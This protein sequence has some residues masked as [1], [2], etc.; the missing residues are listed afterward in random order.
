MMTTDIVYRTMVNARLMGVPGERIAAQVAAG[1]GVLG[2]QQW[3][4]EFDAQWEW[5]VA[6]RIVPTEGPDAVSFY[7]SMRRIV[8]RQLALRE[9]PPAAP[10]GM[11]FPIGGLPSSTEDALS[12]VFAVPFEAYSVEAQASMMGIRLDGDAKKSVM[13][14]S[15]N[16]RLMIAMDVRFGDPLRGNDAAQAAPLEVALALLRLRTFRRSL[17]VYHGASLR[18]VQEERGLA[19]CRRAESGAAAAAV[20][21]D[22]IIEIPMVRP[23]AVSVTRPSA[24][25]PARAAAPPS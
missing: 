1:E 12:F 24:P 18:V 13:P 3:E 23:A 7:A 22:R 9:L 16:R 15:G 17:N 20:T 5:L 6:M 21:C 4:A 2:R 19:I 8:Q 25:F 10:A 14:L 11:L